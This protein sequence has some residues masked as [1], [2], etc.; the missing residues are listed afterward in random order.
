VGSGSARYT[1]EIRDGPFLSSPVYYN[2]FHSPPATAA[3]P[4]R[5]QGWRNIG[6]FDACSTFTHVTGC[7]LAEPPSGPSVSKAPTVLLP[8]L[9]LFLESLDSVHCQRHLPR[10]YIHRGVGRY[11]SKLKYIQSHDHRASDMKQSHRDKKYPNGRV[12]KYNTK[13]KQS[14][15]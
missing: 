8:P 9:A 5:V 6:R 2:R 11:K 7:R 4:I 10:N 3:F 1:P 13:W 14:L 15:H 12:W